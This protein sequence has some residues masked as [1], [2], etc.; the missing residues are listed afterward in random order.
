VSRVPHRITRREFVRASTLSLGAIGVLPGD[1]L[2]MFAPATR[3]YERTQRHVAPVDLTIARTPIVVAGRRAEAV[4]ING[5][6]PG[7][8]IRLREGDEAVIRVTNALH[9]P[10]SIH[11]H[12]IILPNA[13]DGVPLVTFPGIPAGETFEYRFP[14]RQA[15]TYW[16]HSHSG[17]QE[18]LGHYGAIVIEPAKGEEVA[19]DRDYVVQLSD[20]T[21]EDPDSVMSHLKKMGGYYNYQRQ[22]LVS[23]FG[24]HDGSLKDRLSWGRM[25]MDPTD[26]ADVTSAT[27][28]YL[29]NGRSPD[30]PWS[31]RFNAGERVRL[32][33]INSGAA[34]FFDVRIPGLP[35][36][37]V[38]ADGQPVEPVTVDEIRVAI[39][40]TYDVIVQPKEDRAYA[41]FAETLDRSGYT[42]GV[43][44]PRDGLVPDVPERRP[45]RRRSMMDMGM[46]MGGSA[47]PGMSGMKGMAEMPGME[48]AGHG[49]AGAPSG[50]VRHGPDGHGPG[51]S[52]VPQVTS[53][54]LDDPGIG[55]GA[56]GWRV[57]A[58]SDLRSV[59]PTFDERDAERDL[60]LHLT[61][62]MER[63]MWSF[64]GRKYSDARDPI[65]IGLRE[66]VRITLVNDTMMEHPIHLHGMWM[67][68]ENGAGERQPR[69]HTVNVKPA[70]RVSVLVEPDEPGKW[71]FHCHILYHM[72]TGMFRV[73]EVPA[74]G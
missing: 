5:S 52:M 9:E 23:L 16:Y 74:H 67:V 60:E 12:G 51:N 31:G 35:M 71:A 29:V 6:V 21:F 65:P 43:L 2:S 47:M 28:H 11:W 45:R 18:Q 26:L 72:E 49:K 41:V 64:D 66:R 69:K 4:A 70:E 58:Y 46:A 17:M 34:T 55:L 57:L 25:R 8:T 3:H 61:G 10:T 36:T 54:R 73:V 37:V 32:R 50:E 27:L 63:Y 62:N 30:A 56:D 15:G 14:I 40:E 38:Q 13:M 20:W 39:A 59:A 42:L 53:P 7:P 24:G 44:S 48:H 22:T 33:F 68:L 19:A 1:K